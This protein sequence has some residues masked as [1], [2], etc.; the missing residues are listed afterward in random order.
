VK[1]LREDRIRSIP[2]EV[3]VLEKDGAFPVVETVDIAMFADALA[4][5][6]ERIQTGTPLPADCYRKGSQAD[7]LLRDEGIMHLHV[8]PGL[9]NDVLLL[10]GQTDDM[11]V[12]LALVRHSDLFKPPRYAT[13]IKRW[14][15]RPIANLSLGRRGARKPKS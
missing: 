10:V 14:L 2:K 6:R 9:D 7:L 3:Q 4:D 11:V 8:D 15:A 1:F 13:G 12:F 5:I